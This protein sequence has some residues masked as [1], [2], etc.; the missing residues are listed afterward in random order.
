MDI[1][2]T[3]D[4]LLIR[5]SRAYHLL[6][7]TFLIGF[8]GASL[9]YAAGILFL[10][11]WPAHVTGWQKALFAGAPMLFGVA[12]AWWVLEGRQPFRFDRARGQLFDGPRPRCP[13]DAI[14]AVVVRRDEG[15]SSDYYALDLA[16]T[17]G[18][19]ITLHRNLWSL[20]TDPA[21]TRAKA[22]QLADFL[23]VQVQ[24]KW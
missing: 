18:Q 15:E 19:T 11:E 12:L 5:P 8:G 9:A 3:T 6:G 16:L 17:D 21:A 1:A 13:L 4:E 2:T 7:L 22:R 24:E 10:I 20:D 23:H 14:A